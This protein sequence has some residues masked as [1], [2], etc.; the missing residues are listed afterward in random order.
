VTPDERWL[1]AVWPFVRNH[2]PV[3]PAKVVEIGC[4]PLGGFV[5][6]I[7]REG[8][9]AVGVDP[10]A[11]EGSAYRRIEFEFFP[12]TGPADAVVACTSL[13]HVSDLDEVL[14]RAVGV[15]VPGGA[16]LVVEWAWER[17]DE[18]TARWC[19]AR[20][21]EHEPGSE[22]NWLDRRRDEW[23]ASGRPWPAYCRDWADQERLHT[24]EDIVRALD[25]R[26]DRR[27]CT[28][29]PYFFA[30]LYDT[31]EADE[32]AAIEAG[33][34]MANGIRYVGQLR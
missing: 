12:V 1:A 17:F 10:D 21:L 25:A 2:L 18:A 9:D 6:T 34:I 24:G 20:R 32:Q 14:D 13:H 29:G 7:R 16:A 19:F 22:P 31:T 28:F 30:D 15:L 23:L 26:F 11:P 4:G 27:T 8:Y 33:R 5:P 3:A